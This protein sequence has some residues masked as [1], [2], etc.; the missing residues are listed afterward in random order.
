MNLHAE[1]QQNFSLGRHATGFAFLDTIYRERRDP[2]QT[3]QLCLAYH[4]R[5]AD[6]SDVVLIHGPRPLQARRSTVRNWDT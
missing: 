5:F 6:F 1:R 2:G 3:R 4:L